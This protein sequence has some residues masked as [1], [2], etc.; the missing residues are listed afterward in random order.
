MNTL[1]YVKFLNDTNYVPVRWAV[2][3]VSVGGTPATTNLW[4]K[5][6]GYGWDTEENL[7]EYAEGGNHNREGKTGT[8]DEY[9]VATLDQV[10]SY[11][12]PSIPVINLR[13]G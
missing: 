5:C 8:L 12:R 10:E 11:S 7:K 6:A 1:E 13:V 2:V 3:E 9:I 4:L